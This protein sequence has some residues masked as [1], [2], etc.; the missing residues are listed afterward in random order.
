MQRRPVLVWVLIVLHFL[1]PIIKTLAI[2]LLNE[3]SPLEVIQLTTT[4]GV[5]EALNKPF[6]LRL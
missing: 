2:G 3:A 6:M 4:Y 1:E 5:Q